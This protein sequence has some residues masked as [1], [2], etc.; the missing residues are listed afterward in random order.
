LFDTGHNRKT[1][2]LDAHSIAIVA[3][4]TPGLREV[5]ADG[6]LEALRM[7][8]DRHDELAHRRVQTVNRVQ[9]LLSRADPR[10]TQT[11]PLRPAGQGDARFGPSA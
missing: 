11:R 3:V 4:R 6:E 1:D 10:T 7:L 5:A 2:A 9:R 8:T